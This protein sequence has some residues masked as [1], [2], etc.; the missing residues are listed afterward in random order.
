MGLTRPRLNQ[1]QDSDFKN[2]CRVVQSTNITMSGGAPATVDYVNLQVGDRVLAVG[3]AD[4]SEN[5][6]YFVSS[7]GSGD[8]GTWVRAL[9]F[10]SN[11]NITSGI[12][13]ATTEGT[14]YGSKLWR[15]TTPDPIVIGSTALAFVSNIQNSNIYIKEVSVATSP[16]Q[17]DYI[18]AS[19]ITTVQWIVSAR[20]LINGT[21]RT[22]VID[23]VTNGTTVN[24]SEHSILLSDSAHEV[25]TSTV[26]ITDGNIV[27]SAVG[28][29]V[30]CKVTVQRM[31]LGSSTT[32]GYVG[33]SVLTGL[34][35]L[36]YD[37]T[38]ELGGNLNLNSN[39][40]SGSGNIELTGD[41]AV[42]GT[43]ISMPLATQVD[44]STSPVDT[45]ALSD[46][47]AAKYIITVS[48]ATNYNVIEALVVHNGSESTI[49]IYGEVA[50]LTSLGEFSTD[51]VNDV[52]RLLYTGSG[53]NNSVKVYATYISN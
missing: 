4:A 15:L 43:V 5:G 10:N 25:I 49:S 11:A 19:G 48:N 6:V 44:T 32:N 46:Y 20:D 30:S 22:S 39:T 36:V 17:V 38:P 3:Q 2:S 45:F 24:Y 18:N 8:N 14:D 21:Y 13:L 1:L 9:D 27:L 51:I 37:L 40:I 41:I 31:S 26:S 52:V 12:M 7:L 23:A 47:R 34:T 16:V 50:T 42:S 29:S 28:D 33:A 53:N 35:D